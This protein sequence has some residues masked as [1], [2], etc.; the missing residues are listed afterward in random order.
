[1]NKTVD[2][3]LPTVN[4]LATLEINRAVQYYELILYHLR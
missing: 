3:L 1:M 2:T 4:I